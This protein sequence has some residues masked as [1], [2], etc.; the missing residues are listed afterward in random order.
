MPAEILTK[1]IISKKHIPEDE[2][3]PLVL[4]PNKAYLET[5]RERLTI[6]SIMV[7]LSALMSV[8]I[9]NVFWN[10]LLYAFSSV[11]LLSGISRI[12]GK[13]TYTRRKSIIQKPAQP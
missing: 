2:R 8:F 11:F 10:R 5:E 13:I 12:T 6:K 7:T 9:L 4:H 3:V 1:K